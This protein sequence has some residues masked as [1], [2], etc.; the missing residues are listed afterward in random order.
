MA[1]ATK[2]YAVVTGGNKGIG[3]GICRKLA[4]NGVVVLLTARDEKKGLEAVQKLR[5]SGL[6]DHVLFHQ[7]DVADTASIASLAD[8]IKTKYGKLDILVNNAGI[9]GTIV[10]GDALAALGLDAVKEGAKIDLS[11]TETH[12]YEL[13]EEC[14]KTN[15][16]GAKGMIEALLPILHLSNSPRIVNVSSSM[17]HLE[18]IPNEWAKGVLGDAES[19]TEERV[20]EVLSEFRKDLKEGSLETKGWP[21]YW[22]AYVVS[23]AAVNAYTRI[24]AKKFSSFRVNCVCPGYVKTDINC[25]TGNLT[26]DEGAE[27]VVTLALLPN[28]G[29]SGLFFYRNEVTTFE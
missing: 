2:K 6:S 26:I 5:D 19:L 7:L 4:S 25:N 28:D 27:S 12:T 14:L 22:S 1:D 3:F 23:K 24:V 13:A 9:A 15:Y 11:K 17:G 21:S 29:P 18:N 20:D 10:D 16:Y 8:F